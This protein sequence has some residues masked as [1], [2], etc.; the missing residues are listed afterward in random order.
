MRAFQYV[1]R[2]I[3]LPACALAVLCAVPS[4][5]DIFSA[6]GFRLYGDFR[7]RLEADWDSQTANGIPRD[8]RT[9]IRVRARAGLEY[10][11]DERFTFGLRLRSGSD[12]S[13]QS[14]HITVVD[15]DDNDTG[16]AHFNFDK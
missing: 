6:D 9:R 2:S 11:P 12:D 8:D 16:D 1:V 4:R 14:P 7:A 13:H 10:A 5:A 15:L 3:S